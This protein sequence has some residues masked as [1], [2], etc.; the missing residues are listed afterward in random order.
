LLTTS[1][2]VYLIAGIDH[3]GECDSIIPSHR[4]LS[5][6]LTFDRHAQTTKLL[7]FSFSNFAHQPTSLRHLNIFLT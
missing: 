4:A 5:S 1:K 3:E 2:S 6:S 7:L